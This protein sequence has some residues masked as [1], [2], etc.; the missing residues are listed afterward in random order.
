MQGFKGVF[1]GADFEHGV[2]QLKKIIV[3]L[4]V[5]IITPGNLMINALS[6]SIILKVK[7]ESKLDASISSLR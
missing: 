6:V 7:R 5:V 4:G 1:E 3:R 2:S